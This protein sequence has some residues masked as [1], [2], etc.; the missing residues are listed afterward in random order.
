MEEAADRGLLR[1]VTRSVRPGQQ[2]GA[3]N[4]TTPGAGLRTDRS[5][6]RF[7][8]RRGCRSA[9]GPSPFMLNGF[10]QVIVHLGNFCSE[11]KLANGGGG[12]EGLLKPVPC[13]EAYHLF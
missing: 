5:L 13:M 9:F 1:R 4:L 6:E 2:A 11:E 10:E 12:G 3:C 8:H 7:G